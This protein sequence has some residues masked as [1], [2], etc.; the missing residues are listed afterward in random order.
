MKISWTRGASLPLFLAC[1]GVGQSPA[2]SSRLEWISRN[3]IPIR[4]IDPT[5]PN[6]NFD[7][8]EPLLDVIG[9]SR[10]VVLGE[11]SH[12]DGATFLAKGRIIKFL[13]QRLGFDV[14]AWEAGLFNCSDMNDA[15]REPDLPLEEVMK[16][17]LFPIWAKSVQVRPVFEYARAVAGTS[18]PLELTGFD[19]QFSGTAG[20]ALRWR[21][22]I[23]SYVD[24][25]DAAILPEPV[26][27]SLVNDAHK[28]FGGN[29]AKP[30]EIRAVAEKWKAL[31]G[32]L[33]KGRA[34]LVSAHGSR[35]AE[36]M[37]RTADDALVSLE[38]L[39]RFREAAGAFRPSDNNMRDQR[40]AENLIWLAND[41]YKGRR[42]I[43]WAAAFHALHDPSAIRLEPGAGFSYQG[44]LTMGQIARRSFGR[45]MYTIGFIAAEGRAGNEATGQRLELGSPRGG[46][47]EDLCLRSGARFLLVDFR[48]LPFA[49]WLREEISASPLGYS[50]IVTDWP[51]QFDALLFT[52][53][54]FPSG[55]GPLAPDGAVLTEAAAS[56]GHGRE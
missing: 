12:G 9:N 44:V 28:V 39:A 13:H 36:L 5:S 33:D 20:S 32:A 14:L 37:R 31:P 38:G 34:K 46:S 23:I 30:P 24:K 22:A 4:S 8:L 43:V 53:T 55:S 35:H 15:L 7:D 51:R 3:A 1:L 47:L 40:M 19:H 11:Q 10:I 49:H 27:K 25:A 6:D 56:A 41:R 48:S 16:R 18:K 29:E 45:Q 54:M 17:G 21:D 2:S 42:L 52:R 26:R 50:P